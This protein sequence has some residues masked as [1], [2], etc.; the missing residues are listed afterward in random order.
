MSKWIRAVALA[1]GISLVASVCRFGEECADIR[2]EVL[3]LH[4]LA[5]SDSEEDQALKLKVR[6]AVVEHAAGLFDG[7]STRQ[8]AETAVQSALGELEQVAQTC[9]EDAGYS[10]PVKV[11]LTDMYFTTRTY[12]TVTLPAGEYDAVRVSIGEAKGQNWWCVVFPPLCVSAAT[13]AAEVNDVLTKPQQDIVQNKHRYTVRFK[14]VEWWE[15][16]ISWF[17][18]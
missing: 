3:R 9:V 4:V 13:D 6:D 12:D 10:Y 18:G 15:S 2:N 7:L 14:L 1:L 16:L 8:Q 5:N 11:E 17:R